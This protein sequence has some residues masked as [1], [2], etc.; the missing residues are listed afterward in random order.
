MPYPKGHYDQTRKK[1]IGSAR[2][3]FNRFGFDRVSINAIMKD[4][5]LTRGAFYGYFDSKS[6][7]YAEV[8]E[9]FSLI[10]VGATLGRECTLT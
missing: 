8:L 4:A 3:L 1:I 2:K 9:C 10:R 6:D 5:A 7:L